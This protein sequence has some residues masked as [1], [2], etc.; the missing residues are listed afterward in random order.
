MQQKNNAKIF[1][2]MR[3]VWFDDVCFLGKNERN[4]KLKDVTNSYKDCDNVK[5]TLIRFNS[6]FG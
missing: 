6:R 1:I 2:I 5:V 3:T 4:Y